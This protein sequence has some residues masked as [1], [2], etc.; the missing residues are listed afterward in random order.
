MRGTVVEV[1]GKV[2]LDT[3]TWVGVPHI[4]NFALLKS[5]ALP[6]NVCVPWLEDVR[7]VSA[8]CLKCG[9]GRLRFG[10]LKQIRESQGVAS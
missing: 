9:E 8:W 6:L 4:S 2:A 10:D 7:F 1:V 5:L 3:S